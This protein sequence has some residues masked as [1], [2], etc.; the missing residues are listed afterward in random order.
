[1]PSSERLDHAALGARLDAIFSF[2]VSSG[3]NYD[4]LIEPL[5]DV[6][7]AT[8]DFALHWATVAARTHLEIAYL[9]VLLV[10]PA[11]RRLSPR[12]AEAWVVAALDGFD[13]IGLRAAVMRLRD[14]EGF[15]RGV[16]PAAVSLDAITPRLQRFLQGLSGRSLRVEADNAVWTDTETVFLPPLIEL[17]SH[18]ASAERYLVLAALLWAQGRWGSYAI[19][20]DAALAGF[21]R[22]DHALGWLALLEARRLGARLAQELPG[23]RGE[24]ASLLDALPSEL[25][26]AREALAT[27]GGGVEDSIAWLRDH[28][29]LAVSP[30]P[31]LG[32]LPV[33]RP[34]VARQVRA[35]RIREQSQVLR[36]SIAELLEAMQ[37]GRDGT[38]ELEVD[39]DPER[40]DLDLR[41]DGASVTL[42]PEGLAAAQSLLQDLGEI[43]PDLL[44]PAGPAEW[45]GDGK[46]GGG[47]PGT[48]ETHADAL[49]DEWDYRRRAYRRKWCHV[50]LHQVGGGDLAYVPAVRA[51]HAPLIR[52]LRRRFEAMR[53]EDRV[54]RRQADGQEVDM[55][56]LVAA[57]AD[58]RGGAEPSPRLFCR[59]QRDER[60]LAAVFLVDMSGS[61]Q[62]W[63]NDAEREALV[64]LCEALEM[65]DD[66]YAIWGFS[67][68]TR[69][70]CDLY[71]IKDFDEAYD[72]EVQARIAAIQPRDYTRMGPPIRFVTQRLLAEPARHRLLVTISDG[73]PDDF[74]DDYR[75]DYGIEDTR[76]ALLEARRAGVR[77]FCITIDRTGAD[78]LKHMYGPAAYAVLDEVRK[79]PLKVAEIY[80]KL[81]I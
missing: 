65:L 9:V 55:D 51:R 45:K 10:P 27:P 36:L 22:P 5:L 38:P 61:T 44:V 68:W 57:I 73:R 19:D 29:Q 40:L 7:R 52:Q 72:T 12:Q 54:L 81:T 16:S 35:A 26:A 75:S 14:I 79:L 69:T 6:E 43:T 33:L 60:S 21:D 15:A 53:G 2:D 47:K 23:L 25:D 3:R 34:A 70:R 13:R 50:Y 48:L 4:E 1:V 78:Y 41:I 11:L 56:A 46:A 62:G 77:P 49:F 39:T 76:Q 32:H 74:G 17:A 66:R 63:V 80:R 20:I 8:Q 64:L 18:E 24:L 42:P 71:R 28:P 59:R 67:G 37:S 30:A 31:T 58:R